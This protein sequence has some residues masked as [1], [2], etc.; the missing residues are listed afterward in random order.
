[1]QKRVL[2]AVATSALFA[3]FNVFAEAGDWMARVRAVNIDTHNSS[4]PVAGEIG[5]AHV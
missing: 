5:R 4:S 1:M 3:S 2:M